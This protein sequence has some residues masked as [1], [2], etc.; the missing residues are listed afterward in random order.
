MA[1]EKKV[2]KCLLGEISGLDLAVGITC[3]CIYRWKEGWE[4]LWKCEYE[5]SGVLVRDKGLW[6]ITWFCLPT[7]YQELGAGGNYTSRKT[8]CPTIS[9]VVTYKGTP[10]E[11]KRRSY[12]VM[13]SALSIGVS[14]KGWSNIGDRQR[15]FF[16][17]DHMVLPL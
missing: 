8:L 6:R 7:H 14:L 2:D 5:Y 1:L 15:T 17:R 4:N 11:V 16:K 3:M 12:H 13:W 10:L 9:G